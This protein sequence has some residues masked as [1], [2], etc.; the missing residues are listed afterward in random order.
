MQFRIMKRIFT[1]FIILLTSII[2]AAQNLEQVRKYI[3]Y[4]RFESAKTILLDAITNDDASP[5]V[6]YLLG[7]IL[8]KEK[9]IDAATLLLTKG[10]SN[11][12]QQGYSL[13]QHPL[14]YIGY[15]HALLDGGNTSEAKAIM[16]QAIKAGK[17]KNPISLLAAARANIESKNGDPLWAMQLLKKAIS[18]DKKNAE[19]YVTKGDAHRKIIDGSNAV[20]NY[21]KALA[22]NPH[23]ARAMY[24]EGQLYKT[25][26]NTEVFID[27]FLKTV[28]IDSNF[29]PALYELYYHYLY[30][31]VI[32]AQKYFTAYLNHTD[33]NPQHR[34]MQTD[35]DFVSKRYQ[36]AIKGATA[37][38]KADGVQAQPR[39]YKLIAYSQASLG[40]SAAALSNMTSYFEKQIKEKYVTQDYLFQAKLS[41]KINPDKS[42]AISW[43]RRALNSEKDENEKLD[44]MESLAAL[45]KEAE[46]RDREAMWR[47]KIYKSKN[48]PTNID[49][50]KWGIA[51]YS[52]AEYQRADSVFALYE[53]KYP[54]QVY[55][56]LWRARSNALIDTV[57]E[58]GL[59]VP[60]FKKLIKVAIKES[61]KNKES[62]LSAYGYLG[63]YEANINKDFA[64]SL[65][66][67][68]KM[69]EIDPRNSEA[70]KYAELLRKWVE[71]DKESGVEREAAE[72]NASSSDTESE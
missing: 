19:L 45:N 28:A 33:P 29:A 24:K 56:Y 38:L 37:I 52:D 42:V 63:T 11:F 21:K 20:I 57:M 3:Y 69:L 1:L 39:L 17:N 34:Y 35:L 43:Y 40:D 6:Y 59:A 60:H 72:V 55:G 2:G 15:A 27:R 25:Q 16:E 32:K 5:E 66:Y 31:D 12:D 9:K 47:E 51:L 71:K 41:E 13:K 4:E 36:E 23:F 49:L 53:S 64:T 44:Y 10:K 68:D 7:E 18:K 46:N 62:L 61:A 65:I 54:N 67:F 58:Q 30:R 26:K 50:Y 8:L 22:V 14:L 70:S 48:R